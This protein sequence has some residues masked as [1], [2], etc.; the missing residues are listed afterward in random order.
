M[1][2]KSGL[3]IHQQLDTH[4]LFC[5]CPSVLRSD[6]PDV[7]FKRRLH[8]V[9]GE[10]GEVD[11][12]AKHEAEKGREFVYQGYSDTNCLVEYDDEPPHLINQEALKTALH[13]ALHLNCVILPVSQIMR[14]TVVDGSNTS[15]FQRTVLIARDGFVETEAG[16]VRIENVYL[17]EDSARAVSEGDGKKT[18]R[19]DR[20][21]I[22]LVEIQTAPDITTPEQAKEVALY[23]GDVLRSCKV[24][25]GIGTIRQDVNVSIEGHPRVEIKGFQDAK[26]FIPV[27]EKEIE[28][29]EK[30]IVDGKTKSEVRRA[31]EDGSTEFL[32]PMPGGA[33]MYP[34]TDLPLLRI[35]RDIINE[36]RRTLPRLRSDVHGEYRQKGLNEE[37]LKF[38]SHGDKIEEFESLLKIIN[39]PNFIARV[40]FLIPRE[41]GK[42]EG[43]EDIDEV[44]NLDVIESI[45]GAVAKN[46]IERDDVKHVMIEIA[47]G[48]NFDEAV[49]VEKVDLSEVESEIA[50]MIK[51]K[52]GLSVGGYMGLIMQKF[53]GKVSGREA[54]EILRK[55]LG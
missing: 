15:G 49:V 27:I 37:M 6:E 9:A 39:E 7:I 1:E 48:K 29:Q 50:Q 12:A 14:K 16:K 45:V 18:F 11:V 30:N 33:R 40:L 5:N 3:E 21:G 53:K 54:G 19:I 32:R 22:P 2:I 41:I 23:I 43:I 35:L 17:E 52:P 38:L 36:A 51:E 25:R 4:K 20:L 24:K 28:R 8:A 26:M 47:K 55:L 31:N 44:L 34:E 10:S 42:H 46:R 13:I